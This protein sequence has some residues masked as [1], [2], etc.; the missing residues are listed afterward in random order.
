MMDDYAKEFLTLLDDE[1]NE[2]KFELLDIVEYDDEK[3]YALLP[4][5]DNKKGS[6]N[7][8]ATYDY[9]IFQE[10]K[11]STEQVLAEVEDPFKLEKIS[12][13]V[14]ERLEEVWYNLLPS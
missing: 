1:G 6:F 2:H 12:K 9:Y 5:K 8:D 10:I 4:K 11:D 7:E 13:I 14:E 3:F